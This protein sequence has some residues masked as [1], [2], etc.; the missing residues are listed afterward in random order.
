[1][2]ERVSFISDGLGLSGVLQFPEP[3]SERHA[4]FLVLH[5]FGSNKDGGGGKA[6]A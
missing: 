5:G 4:A 6:V 2:E 3:R 1:M